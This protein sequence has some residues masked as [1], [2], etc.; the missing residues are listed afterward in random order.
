MPKQ[1]IVEPPVDTTIP[2]TIENYQWGYTPGY[3]DWY[4]NAFLTE[5][6][7]SPFS[8]PLGR[9]GA[10]TLVHYKPRSGSPDDDGYIKVRISATVNNQA[11]P[12]H[13]QTFGTQQTTGPAM[14]QP[15]DLRLFKMQRQEGSGLLATLSQL[16]FQFLRETPTKSQA[17]QASQLLSVSHQ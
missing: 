14:V 9:R 13:L 1:A 8:Q 10:A 12:R 2:Q 11:G 4:K 7:G 5:L 16:R 15:L 6:L 17:S 3:R